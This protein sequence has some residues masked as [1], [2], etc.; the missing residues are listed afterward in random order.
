LES[1]AKPAA[2]DDAEDDD[3]PE[4]QP[5]EIDNEESNFISYVEAVE[6]LQKLKQ[7]APKLGVN[8]AATVHLDRFLNSRHTGNAKKARQDTTLRA[9]F[10][11]KQFVYSLNPF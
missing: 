5:M 1:N 7:S 11:K 8:E 9:F 3:E 6:F 4:P 2:N 10:T